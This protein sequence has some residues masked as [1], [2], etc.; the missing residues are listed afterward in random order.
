VKKVLVTGGGGFLGSAIARA[1]LKR[2]DEVRILA[3]G[4]YPELAAAG[5]ELLRGDISDAAVCRKAC[6]GRDTVFHVAA[7]IGL[8]G[9]YEDFH[10]ANVEGTKNLLNACL[11]LGVPRFVFSGSPS[12][13]FESFV[14]CDGWDET[15]PYPK[16]FDGFYSQTKALAEEQVLLANSK[17]LATVSL[18]PHLIWGPGDNHIIWRLI[19]KSKAGRLKR[20]GALNKLVD[21]TYI[22]D[23]VEGHLLAAEKLPAVGGKAYFLSQG[24]PWPIW[25]FINGMLA[26]AGQPP[27]ERSVPLPVAKAAASALELAWTALG[28]QDEPP[29]TRFLVSQMST[30]H[31]FDISAAKRDLGYRP[32]VSIE[33]GMRRLKDWLAGAKAPAAA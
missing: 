28:R 8:W 23:C 19:E 22:D 3:R 26:A 32:S 10:K 15:A 4:S 30:A 11:E 31:W 6:E 20:I 12:V 21:T 2:G 5:A 1:L 18:R 24:D 25:K 27:A 33:E 7:K 16:K 17:S 14:D 13:V 29:L 9:K